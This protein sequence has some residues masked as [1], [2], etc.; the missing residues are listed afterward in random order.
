MKPS[1]KPVRTT[2]VMALAF[3]LLFIPTSMGLNLILPWHIA[4]RLTFWMCV[5]A[6]AGMLCRWTGSSAPA[7]G[8]PLTV[9][10]AS[11]F[12]LR[13][14]IDFLCLLALILAWV[15]SAVCFK[16]PVWRSFVA[17]LVVSLGGVA[18]I[19]F[20]GPRS[21]VVWAMGVWMFFLIQSLYF[22]LTG[23]LNDADPSDAP[24]DPFEKARRGAEE[25]LSAGS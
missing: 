8:F 3:G 23:D 14:E 6:Y 24:V 25:I 21:P 4:L 10:L 1:A 11:S 22:L 18:L 5:A 17:E 9:L 12:W 15:R 2:I 20:F 19:A 13:S 16:H 7:C